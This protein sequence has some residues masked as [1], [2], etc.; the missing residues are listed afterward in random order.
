M[1]SLKLKPL[2]GHATQVDV[3]DQN[4]TLIVYVWG[5]K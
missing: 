3:I 1:I 2:L 5:V 4:L